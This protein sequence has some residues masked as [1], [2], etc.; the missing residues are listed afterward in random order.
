MEYCLE[1]AS[2]GG[3][4]ASCAR[5]AL[6]S[7]APYSFGGRTDSADAGSISLMRPLHD[8]EPDI[9]KATIER[10]HGNQTE[11]ARILQVS[12]TTIWRLLK[13]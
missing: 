10:C 1:H 7:S 6:Q 2:G 3:I 12:R 9:M 5:Q 11:A 4:D 13:D 8:I